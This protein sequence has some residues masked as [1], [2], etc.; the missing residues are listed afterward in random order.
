MNLLFFL[1]PKQ[2]VS[3]VKEEDSV[4][5]VIE[6]MENHGYSAIPILNS[7]G[8]YAG[9]ITEGD[10]LWY[11]KDHSFPSL[12]D[13]ESISIMKVKR[14]RD[15]RA[16]HISVDMDGLVDQAMNQNFV[17]IVDDHSVFIGIVTRKDLISYLSKQHNF[18]NKCGMAI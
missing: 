14:H 4:R 5:Q 9:T 11:L 13:L 15:N 1:T 7:S 8:Q 10:I 18:K 6:K 12:K 3:V 16:V 17:P 2:D